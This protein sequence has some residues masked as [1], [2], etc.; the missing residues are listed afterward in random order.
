[1][2]KGVVI[3]NRY[4]ARWLCGER[5]YEIKE[6]LAKPKLDFSYQHAW[7]KVKITPGLPAQT[8]GVIIFHDIQELTYGIVPGAIHVLIDKSSS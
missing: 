1:M 7:L 8:N 4:S 5:E 6:T 3:H 2:S